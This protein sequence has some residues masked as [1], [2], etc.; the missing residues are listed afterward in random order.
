MVR[1]RTGHQ[2]SYAEAK[3][4]NSLSFHTYGCHRA[5]IRDCFSSSSSGNIVISL[6]KVIFLNALDEKL[7]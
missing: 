4:M 7:L 5:S 1:K 2:P 6:S 3:K